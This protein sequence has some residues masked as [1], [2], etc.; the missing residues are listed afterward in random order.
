M[1]HRLATFL[2]TYVAE[3][4]P[5]DSVWLFPS[6]L[7]KDGKPKPKSKSGNTVAI[8]K[9]LR[10]AAIAAGLVSAQVVRH[11]LRHTAATHLVQSG[12][13]LPTVKRIDGWKTLAMVER[14]AHQNCEHI[15]AA[16]DKLE[17]ACRAAKSH[18][19]ITPELHPAAVM[20]KACYRFDSR[21]FKNHAGL[22]VVG[23]E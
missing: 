6:E 16:M 23:P 1:T 19:T 3:S 11:T 8:Q 12:V 21:L 18:D 10:L 5:A 7:K 22:L 15:Q 2:Q 20:K 13:D 17:R 4:V 9:P 14:Y